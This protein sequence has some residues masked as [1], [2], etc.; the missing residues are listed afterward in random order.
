M[1]P[2]KAIFI[3]IYCTYFQVF[4]SKKDPERQN[5]SEHYLHCASREWQPEYWQEVEM[6]ILHP[7]QLLTAY[8]HQHN[9]ET[10]RTK[11]KQ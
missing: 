11:V 3:Y 6:Q 7:P 5:S 2:S 10:Q 8:L 4:R 9:L 1:T